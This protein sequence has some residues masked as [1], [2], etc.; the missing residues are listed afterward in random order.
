MITNN[1]GFSNTINRI[2]SGVSDFANQ[3]GNSINQNPTLQNLGNQI[4]SK[5]ISLQTLPSN[6]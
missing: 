2:G 4:E 6:F 3:V 1:N 5:W